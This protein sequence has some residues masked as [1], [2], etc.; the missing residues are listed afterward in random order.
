[1]SKQMVLF[2]MAPVGRDREL[3]PDQLY[4]MDIVEYVDGKPLSE[5]V[6]VGKRR[7]L[8]NC[9][10]LKLIE[11]V[12]WGPAIYR[13]TAIGKALAGLAGERQILVVTHLPQVA[14]YADVQIAVSKD[15]GGAMTSS[16]IRQP[17]D[18]LTRVAS[19]LA[20][21]A[22]GVG[23]R[24]ARNCTPELEPNAPSA[25]TITTAAA[26]VAATPST[27]RRT[28]REGRLCR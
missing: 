11:V 12:A 27:T 4:V 10:D 18:V 1:M 22:D 24:A 14:A 26:V 5:T 15:T 28:V 3:T 25:T 7:V 8:R 2:P 19:P 13:L 21:G 9:V 16:S 6:H 23:P 20:P 17:D